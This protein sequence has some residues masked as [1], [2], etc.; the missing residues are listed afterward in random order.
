MRDFYSNISLFEKKFLLWKNIFFPVG[1][2]F[3]VPIGS[4]PQQLPQQPQQVPQ[5]QIFPERVKCF[6]PG[7]N[8][9]GVKQGQTAPFTILP[10]QPVN[11][12]VNVTVTEPNTGLFLS[13]QNT[14]KNLLIV[15]L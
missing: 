15:F 9:Q 10:N 3:I 2:S 4:K 12:A 7:L 5:Q 6:G 1:S 8:P 14:V 11:A 13:A